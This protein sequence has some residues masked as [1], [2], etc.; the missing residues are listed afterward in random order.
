MA[1][2]VGGEDTRPEVTRRELLNYAWLA[3]LGLFLTQL[4][5]VTY[6][7][8]MPR[9][10]VGQFGGVFAVGPVADFP[11][12][13]VPELV[14]GG[15]FY[16]VRFAEGVLALYQV[17]THLGCLVPWS[18]SAGRFQCPCHGSQF[19]RD[20][21]YI[22]GPAPRAMDRFVV[23]LV[24]A[25]GQVIAETPADGS[26]APMPDERATLVVDTSRRIMGKGRGAE[27]PTSE[28]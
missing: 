20:G 27:Y 17:C 12:D 18:E 14:A 13:A 10:R 26:A 5:G 3:S 25:S 15:K 1:P 24:D 8:A 21:T 28:T 11:L 7:F 16:V 19:Q 4:G 9:F 23:R 2:E 6:L 22:S